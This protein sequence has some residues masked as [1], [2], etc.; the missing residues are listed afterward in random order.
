MSSAGGVRRA[1][2][3]LQGSGWLSCRT[4]DVKHL[5]AGSLPG[6]PVGRAVVLHSAH[7]DMSD[8]LSVLFAAYSGLIG[9]SDKSKSCL[10]S[11]YAIFFLPGICLN[12][13]LVRATRLC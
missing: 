13:G 5:S 12:F 6:T 4:A 10:Y 9:H 8:I 3:H 1:R 11:K 7:V 2:C